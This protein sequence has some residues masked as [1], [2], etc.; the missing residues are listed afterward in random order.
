MV[1]RNYHYEL[2]TF[3][4]KLC[5]LRSA[6][7]SACLTVECQG[8]ELSINLQLKLPGLTLRPRPSPSRLRRRARRAV[9]AAD[10]AVLPDSLPRTHA[11]AA[12][13]AGQALQVAAPPP[14]STSTTS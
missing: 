5:D 11:D 2:Q 1:G 12:V 14:P 9:A 7:K 13:Q 10:K 3:V 6:G 8:F 4:S